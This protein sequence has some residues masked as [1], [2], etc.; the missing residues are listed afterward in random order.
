M[1]NTDTNLIRRDARRVRSM[2]KEFNAQFFRNRLSH[3][4]VRVV[5][6]IPDNPKCSGGYV[7]EKDLILIRCDVAPNESDLRPVLLHEMCHAATSRDRGHSWQFLAQ[8]KRLQRMGET[9]VQRQLDFYHRDVMSKPRWPQLMLGRLMRIAIKAPDLTWDEALNRLAKE[10]SVDPDELF[11][12]EPLAKDGWGS[13]TRIV[14][15]DPSYRNKKRRQSG[16]I[17]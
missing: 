15:K 12:R 6:S 13:F 7:W 5:R 10:L 11:R 8:L 16:Q 9:W 1:E 14:K 3:C 4:D 17:P 2:F